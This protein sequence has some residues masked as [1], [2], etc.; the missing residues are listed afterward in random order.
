M[1]LVFQ[2]ALESASHDI[3]R[4]MEFLKPSFWLKREQ[5]LQLTRYIIIG[6]SGALAQ[7]LALTGL[8]EHAH[9]RAMPANVAGYFV[10]FVLCFIGHRFWTFANTDKKATQLLSQ[11][12]LITLMNFLLNQS[13]FYVL[14]HWVGLQYQLALVIDLAI[15]TCIT[16]LLNKL[17]VFQC[18]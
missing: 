3:L 4:P 14:L 15:V 16:F 12:L 7:F 9:W 1:A 10:G 13:L 11:Y 17:W 6:G 5:I 8:V 2:I 18:S